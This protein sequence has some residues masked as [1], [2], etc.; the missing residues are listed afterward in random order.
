MKGVGRREVAPVS[1]LPAGNRADILKV[2]L[3]SLLLDVDRR[4][5]KRAEDSRHRTAQRD[6]VALLLDIRRAEGPAGPIG[7]VARPI[8]GDERK[9]ELIGLELINPDRD[10]CATH[11]ALP[12]Q[13]AQGRHWCGGANTALAAAPAVT[14]CKNK[15]VAP[16]GKTCGC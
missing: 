2:P 13:T 3:G 6:R 12:F 10:R 14:Q 4:D 1:R 9:S 11:G 5:D 7:K 8:A 15:L 16:A